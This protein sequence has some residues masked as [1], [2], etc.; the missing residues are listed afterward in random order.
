MPPLLDSIEDLEKTVITADAL[1]TQHAHG[2][3]LRGRGAR[4]L[5]I[6]KKNHTK[7]FDRV[8][9]LPW[10]DM[11]LEYYDRTRAHHRIEICR[12]KAAAFDHINYPDAK[13]AL[14]IVRWRMDR[15]TG[16]LSIERI[17]LI[18]SLDAGAAT[19]TELASW[20][21][22]HWGIGNL[23]HH[24]RDR[25]FREDESKTER[26]DQRGRRPPPCRPRLPSPP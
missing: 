18:T 22:G 1:H 6:V 21:R 20:I 26:P 14:Q 19:G 4:Y 17:Y 11:P 12:L 3:Y 24:V 23:L 9:H 8:R 7:L 25:T 5:A 16:Q 13:Q 2:A 10:R 15:S